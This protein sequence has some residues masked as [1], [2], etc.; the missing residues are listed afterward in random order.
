MG[1]YRLGSRPRAISERRRVRAGG[2]VPPR[3]RPSLRSVSSTSSLRPDAMSAS[4]PFGTFATPLARWFAERTTASSSYSAWL[5]AAAAGSSPA[6]DPVVVEQRPPHRLPA[7]RDAGDG[8]QH[9]PGREVLDA[10]QVVPGGY[11]EPE[12][13][14]STA[15][16]PPVAGSRSRLWTPWSQR[17]STRRREPRPARGT[18]A[19]AAGRP[20]GDAVDGEWPRSTGVAVRSSQSGRTARTIRAR[21]S[22]A[23]ARSSDIVVADSGRE[24]TDGGATRTLRFLGNPPQMTAAV[25]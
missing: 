9:C 8:G 13:P 6:A 20:D 21:V 25:W 5:S 14:S 11:G 15:P 22:S 4:L 12:P 24:R 18:T 3:H 2:P 16:R 1:C 17:A 19:G 7:V 10:L 23:M